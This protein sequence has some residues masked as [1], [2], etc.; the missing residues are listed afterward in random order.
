MAVALLWLIVWQIVAWAVHSQVLLASPVDVLLALVHLIPTGGFWV[1]VLFSATRIL[2]GFLL[3]MVVGA[4]LG[5]AGATWSLAEAALSPLMRVL[6]AVPVVSFVLLVLVWASSDSLSIVISFIMVTPI[7][8]SNVFSGLAS[9][10]PSLIEMA[11]VFRLSLAR[12]WWAITLPALMPFLTSAARIGLGLC[13]KAG[14][15]AEVIGLTSGSIGE[16]LYQAK[17]FLAT[18]DLF[19]WTAVVVG[20]AWAV[21]KAGLAGLSVL[22]RRLTRMYAT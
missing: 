18:G 3:A 20:L 10:D 15:S 14:V 7:V 19:A 8:Y 4:V 5:L 12:R 1:T 13:W 22:D 21:E 11:Q 17:L 16:R 6:Q 2:A 9:R